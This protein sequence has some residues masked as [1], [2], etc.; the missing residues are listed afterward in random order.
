M[1]GGWKKHMELKLEQ[2]VTERRNENTMNLDMMSPLEIVTVMNQE[3]LLIPA[4]IKPHLET[5]AKV[6]TWGTESVTNGGRIFY[7]GAGTSG[8]LGVL[9]ASECPPTFGVSPDVVIG[10]IAGGQKAFTQAVEGAEDNYDLGVSDLKEHG[11]TGKDLVIGLAAS[12]RTPYVLGGLEYAKS[13]G[14]HT[15]AITC[16]ADS[17]LS[18]AAEAGIDIVIGPEVLTGSTRLKAG[19]AQKMVL[20]MI[21]TA[22][23]VGAG[24]VYE[25]LM[26]DVQQSNEKLRVRARRIVRLATEADDETIEKFLEA[27]NG[28]CKVAI[29]MILGGCDAEEARN[30]LEQANGHVRNAVK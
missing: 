21:S 17:V 25:N 10:L 5:I 13:I 20:N 2:M 14:C 1:S 27:A 26:V 23:M 7:M 30:R 29:T 4:A 24:K 9:D 22:V 8:R 18:K 16:N 3:D 19:T 15:A 12:G 6:V 11:L 28:S